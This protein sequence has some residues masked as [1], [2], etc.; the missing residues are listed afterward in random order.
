MQT[1]A[2]F[3]ARGPLSCSKCQAASTQPH[4][5]SPRNDINVQGASEHRGKSGK[6]GINSHRCKPPS[7]PTATDQ[8][9]RWQ[10]Q[11]PLADIF[12]TG[13]W[14]RQHPAEATRLPRACAQ[15][16]GL[17]QKPSCLRFVIIRVC[18]NLHKL[19]LDGE[20]LYGQVVLPVV[21]QTF[22][23]TGVLLVGRILG[24]AHPQW[25][26]Q[27]PFWPRGEH[28]GWGQPP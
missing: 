13:H 3:K 12:P 28:H 20:L 2:C 25:L 9:D 23:E 26:I 18:H 16:R 5:R 21:R 27:S 24:L 6:G 1:R 22:V 19:A 11:K 17:Y 14:V 15:A 8:R 10:Q 4:Q 7:P